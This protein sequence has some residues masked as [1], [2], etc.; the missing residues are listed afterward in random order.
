MSA[1]LCVCTP[2]SQPFRMNLRIKTRKIKFLPKICKKGQKYK[3]FQVKNFKI[4][5]FGRYYIHFRGQW[6]N[7]LTELP[8]TPPIADFSAFFAVFWKSGRS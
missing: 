2:F 8:T 6:K 4:I 3:I 1:W 5:V 7:D